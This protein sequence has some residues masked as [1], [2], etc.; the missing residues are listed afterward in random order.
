VSVIRTAA[1]AIPR[2]QLGTYIFISS[3][4][5]EVSC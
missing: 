3:P 1:N 4:F 5:A 2:V